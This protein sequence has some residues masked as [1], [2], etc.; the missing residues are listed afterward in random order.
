[1]SMFPRNYKEVHLCETHASVL[2]KQI[3]LNILKSAKEI[4]TLL[5]KSLSRTG[6]STQ[7]V[8]KRSLGLVTKMNSDVRSLSQPRHQ[9]ISDCG[10][11]PRLVEANCG[12]HAN[13]ARSRLIYTA[14]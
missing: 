13:V 5:Q 11:S 14:N 6:L 4:W 3:P 12:R 8:A 9:T 2:G 1:L 10:L 7:Q